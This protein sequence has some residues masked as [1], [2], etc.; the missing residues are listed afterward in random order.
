[1]SPF[2]RFFAALTLISLGLAT[3]SFA[4]SV[5]IPFG[6]TQHDTKQPV[7][8]VSDSFTISQNQGTAEF[9]GNVVVGQG[10]MRLSAGK[11]RVE[12]A[13]EDGK[14]SGDIGRMVASGGVTLVAGSEAAEAKTAVYSIKDSSI[15][16]E[17][18]VLLTQSGSAMSAQ[19]VTINLKDG[20]AN[21]EGR[22]KTIFKPGASE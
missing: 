14:P 8:I 10:E 6:A 22:V 7:E 3:T 21:V 1:M 5:K 19:K 18:D 17:G 9:V 4:Q 11:V 2:F 16:M 15:V 20:S 13:V 12:Y